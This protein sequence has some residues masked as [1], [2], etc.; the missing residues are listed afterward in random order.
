MKKSKA[1]WLAYRR[2][3]DLAVAALAQSSLDEA[4]SRLERAHILGQ[5]WPGAH[6][7]THWMMLRIGWRRKDAREVRGQTIRLIASGLLSWIGWLPA[8]NTG[9]A[10]VNPHTPMAPPS[11]LAALC[12][13][14]TS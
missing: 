10:D 7:W 4:F 13:E 14:K 2:E 1:R 5:P 6:T 12:S 8:G 3:A 11:D 9:G